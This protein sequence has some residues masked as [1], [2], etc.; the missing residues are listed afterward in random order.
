MSFLCLCLTLANL[1]SCSRPV[2]G[3][4]SRDRWISCFVRPPVYVTDV[5]KCFSSFMPIVLRTSS[6]ACPVFLMSHHPAGDVLLVEI[7]I[8]HARLEPK[9]PAWTPQCWSEPPPGTHR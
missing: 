1:A 4:K 3:G 2:A 6:S 8:P 9:P 7:V 5:E